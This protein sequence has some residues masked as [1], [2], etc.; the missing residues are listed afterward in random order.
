MKQL[1]TVIF[2]FLLLSLWMAS[3]QNGNSQRPPEVTR[4]TAITPLNAF[5]N[6]FFDSL[7]MEHFLAGRNVP[8]TAKTLFRNFYTERNFQYAWFDSTGLGE[9]AKNFWNLQANHIALTGDSALFNSYLQGMMDS[10]STDSS[11]LL[12]DTARLKMEW[13]LTFQFFRYANRAYS[14]RR[15]LNARDLQ[16]FIPR[17]KVDLVSLLDTLVKEKGKEIDRYEP[18]NRQ[19]NLLL[20]KLGIYYQIQKNSS[21]DTLSTTRKKLQVGDT[22][23]V[24]ARVK[25]RL[26][27][28]G[29]LKEPDTSALFDNK[30]QEAVKMFQHR[31]GLGS[32]GIIGVGTLREMNRPVSHR[33]RQILVNMERIRWVPA[34]PTGDYILV[35]IPEFKAHVFEGG[36]PAFDM[37]VVVGT[38][39][40][41]TVIFTGNIKHVVFSPYWNVPPGIL[42]NEVLPAIRRDP[43]YLSRNDME[44]HNGG[45]RQRP[46]YKNPL[47]LV[48]FLFPNSYNIYLHDTP[49][50]TLFQQSKRAFSHGCIRISEPFRLAQ[51]LLRDDSSWT[52]E[53]ISTAMHAGKEKFVTVNRPVS[54]FIGYF[55]AWVDGDGL[56]N[57]RDDIYGHDKKM[58]DKMFK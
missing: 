47:G 48:K 50:K 56:L 15:N 22:G 43:S 10:L 39:S 18:V 8:D 27:L 52:T 28:L 20:E 19:Y 1:A 31:F 26:H 5:S 33:I 55:T 24:I 6:L 9:Q 38:A 44:W 58:A 36:K 21:W 4:D 35:N 17:K 46:G 7:T 12:P 14:G 41:S 57:F 3:C 23:Y 13:G 37:Q 45:I 54:V 42:K 11:S 25:K 32:D 49:S 34:E 53:T 2:C 30:L 29:D 51:W 16:W 40:N